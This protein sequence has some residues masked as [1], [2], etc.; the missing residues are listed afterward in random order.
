MKKRGLKLKSLRWRMFWLIVWGLTISLTITTTLLVGR[1][2]PKPNED[3]G[4]FSAFQ[5]IVEMKV[6]SDNGVFPFFLAPT[7]FALHISQKIDSELWFLVISESETYSSQNLPPWVKRFALE[8]QSK[9]T[10][11]QTREFY[12]DG[13]KL[14]PVRESHSALSGGKIER[15]FVGGIEKP[16]IIFWI[17]H[18]SAM[19]MLII[20]VALI[21]IPF[22]LLLSFLITRGINKSV[23]ALRADLSAV[24]VDRAFEPVADDRTPEEFQPLLSSFNTTLG[25]LH[26]AYGQ[27]RQ[28]ATELTHELRTPIAAVMAQLQLLDPSKPNQ[29]MFN[30]LTQLHGFIGQLLDSD[31]L[32][33]ADEERAQSDLVVL[34]RDVAAQLAPLAVAADRN[35]KLSSDQPSVAVVTDAT[36]ISHVV[37]NLIA[38][39]IVHGAGEI[40]IAVESG[41]EQVSVSVRDEGSGLHMADVT[42]LTQAFKKGSGKGSGLGLSIAQNIMDR[43]GGKLSGRIAEQGT[44]FTLT[45]P[46][47]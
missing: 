32:R 39:A 28:F 30:R 6:A 20:L 23:S 14:K 31:R 2:Y 29:D 1:D 34:V 10:Y 17:G 35:I 26:E 19:F 18:S 22:A 9:D 24:D 45:L 11:H 7:D 25:K 3:F 36:A 44:E 40:S 47:A 41:P 4:G 13:D 16:G 21:S 15:I 5:R 42:K 46:T 12:F 27:Q 43:L 33:W 37:H 8:H 38:N